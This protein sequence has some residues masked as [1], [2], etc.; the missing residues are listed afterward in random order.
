[1]GF[2]I[3]GENWMAEIPDQQRQFVDKL[4][5]SVVARERCA[6]GQGTGGRSA[7]RAAGTHFRARCHLGSLRFSFLAS[8]H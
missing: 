7:Y 3:A 8:S 4:C 5:G 1:M 2:K 6:A